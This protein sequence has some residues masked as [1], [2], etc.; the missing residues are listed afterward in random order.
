[1]DE[2]F[3]ACRTEDKATC[4]AKLGAYDSRFPEGQLRAESQRL[5]KKALAL[6]ASAKLPDVP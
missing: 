4:L 1:M 6:P 2:A 3:A 5:R